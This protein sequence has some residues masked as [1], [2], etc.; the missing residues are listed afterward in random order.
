MPQILAPSRPEVRSPLSQAPGFSLE[1]VVEDVESAPLRLAGWSPAHEAAKPERQHPP[2]IPPR[3]FQP[4]T[5]WFNPPPWPQTH[6]GNSATPQHPL[7]PPK[8]RHKGT[9]AALIG[10][11]CN[12]SQSNLLL[13]RRSLLYRGVRSLSLPQLQETLANSSLRAVAS[14]LANTCLLFSRPPVSS[15]C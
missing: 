15:P 5:H 3:E 6:C 9:G 12:Q 7:L 14:A 1:P 4:S 2:Q 10:S 8:H 13:F 11:C